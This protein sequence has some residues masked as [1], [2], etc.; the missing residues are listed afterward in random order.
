MKAMSGEAV[1]RLAVVGWV[2]LLA[3][4]LAPAG[5]SAAARH[6]HRAAHP[7]TS[8]RTPDAAVQQVPVSFAVVNKNTSLVPCATDG[9]PYTISGTL[10]LPP[11][12]TPSSATLYAHGLGFGA[13]F[14][15]FTAVPGYDY[16][17]YE[18]EHGH[19][20]VII[21]R[22]GYGASGKPQGAGSCVGGQASILHQVVQDLRHGSYAATGRTAPTF[23]RVGLVGHS[24]G[25]ELVQIEAYSFH[26]IDALG[27]MDFADGP[28]SP[29]ALEEF[30]ID[31][32]QCVL[33]GSPQSPGGP[34]DYGPFGATAGDFD[35][36]MFFDA[37]PA[38]VSATNAERSK[39]PCG[40]V[41]SILNGVA[42]DLLNI[43]SIKVPIAYVWGEDDAL[44]LPV[45]WG[46]AQEGLYLGSPKVTNI[47]LPDTGHAVT[48]ELS[49]PLLQQRMDAWLGAN[50]L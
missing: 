43:E 8:T 42:V 32:T 15:H 13:F 23:S 45:P 33:G 28:F 29:L 21:D 49:A 7:K 38:V 20:S 36:A 31:T 5:A 26:D 6:R 44:F 2:A 22:L 39:D 30:G 1:R 17:T 35:A 9:R 41:V 18:A 4:L 27:V 37:D 47:A 14:W 46:L 16:A 19:A 48:L 25:G 40:D 50:G 24:V 34:G 12:G 10:F 3:A 11:S